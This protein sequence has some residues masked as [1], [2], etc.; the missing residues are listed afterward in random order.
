MGRDL[1]ATRASLDDC[2]RFV[3]LQTLDDYTSTTRRGGVSLG[4]QVFTPDPPPT[5]SP[6]LDAAL[7]A[8][9]QHLAG[10]DGWPPPA[11]TTDPA[12]YLSEPWYPGVPAMWR[13]EADRDSP[14]A[15]R[16]RGIFITSRS[17]ARA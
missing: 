17:L 7:A 4:A 11:W 10:R 15:F 13:D 3:I 2:W 14:P 8:L 1:L 12:R 6:E 9:A 5:G 16:D